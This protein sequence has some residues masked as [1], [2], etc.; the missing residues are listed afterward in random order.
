MY[1][2]MYIYIYV[3]IYIYIYKYLQKNAKKQY[4]GIC[5]TRFRTGFYNYHNCHKKFYK[6]H[7]VI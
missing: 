1:I 4:V 6:G 3:Y 7:Y 2:Y 5:M